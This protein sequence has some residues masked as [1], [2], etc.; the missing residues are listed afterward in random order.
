M[1]KWGPCEKGGK[2]EEVGDRVESAEQRSSD[3][4]S[5]ESV[6]LLWGLSIYPRTLWA[7]IKEWFMGL[8]ESLFSNPS[9]QWD[10]FPLRGGLVNQA[11]LARILAGQCQ[12]ITEGELL[13]AIITEAQ[14]AARRTETH[15]YLAS[16]SEIKRTCGDTGWSLPQTGHCDLSASAVVNDPAEESMLLL[17]LPSGCV[18]MSYRVLENHVLFPNRG[19][20]FL[21]FNTSVQQCKVRLECTLQKWN[22]NIFVCAVESHCGLD[23]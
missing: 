7:L 23:L 6:V 5:W 12:C 9:L 22:W 2:M 13:N 10:S 3:Y 4:D 16:V 21:I 15:I 19:A 20:F 18:G 8:L 14:G 1:A 11:F 17:S